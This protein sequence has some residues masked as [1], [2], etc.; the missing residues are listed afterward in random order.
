[1]TSSWVGMRKA[2]KL[3]VLSL[4][5]SMPVVAPVEPV[6]LA[7]VP[8]LTSDLVAIIA[9]PYSKFIWIG[10]ESLD[11]EMGRGYGRFV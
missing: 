3:P 5:T 9:P 10:V 7:G 4:I 8:Y 6:F 11:G 2:L 1:M